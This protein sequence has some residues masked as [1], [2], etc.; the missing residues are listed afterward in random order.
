[1]FFFVRTGVF[2]FEFGINCVVVCKSGLCRQ[3][4][5]EDT[6]KCF[7]KWEK[8]YERRKKTSKNFVFRVNFIWKSESIAFHPK[9]RKN[10]QS[11]RDICSLS[12]KTNN[13]LEIVYVSLI[14]CNM[15]I[16][17]I[18][19]PCIRLNCSGLEWKYTQL[20]FTFCLCEQVAW[21]WCNYY[22]TRPTIKPIVFDLL[23][24]F[25]LRTQ[26]GH[27]SSR[28][29]MFL[30]VFTRSYECLWLVVHDGAGF[31][32]ILSTINF[33]WFWWIIRN[34]LKIFFSEYFFSQ[35]FLSH[36]F[37]SFCFLS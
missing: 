12:K 25:C 23:P 36:C 21:L 17:K 9:Q 26:R 10:T 16:S 5:S 3:S 20:N 1:M 37:R 32:K 11:V 28:R 4:L 2:V 13:L 24:L 14:K 18:D 30:S 22:A 27:I 35:C 34:P 31:R 15:Q 8:H 19:S 33:I 6:V 29:R 7:R